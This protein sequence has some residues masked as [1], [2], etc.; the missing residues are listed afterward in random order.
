MACR[1]RSRRTARLLAGTSSRYPSRPLTEPLWDAQGSTAVLTDQLHFRLTSGRN[2]VSN[3]NKA[4]PSMV[5]WHT[6]SVGPADMSGR[7]PCGPRR[8]LDEREPQPSKH[9]VSLQPLTV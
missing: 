7:G 9:Q 5:M 4:P 3:R 2:G 1:I 6:A 8:K